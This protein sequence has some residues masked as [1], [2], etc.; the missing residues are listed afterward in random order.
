MFRDSLQF[1]ITDKLQSPQTFQ[2]LLKEYLVSVQRLSNPDSQFLVGLHQ[3]FNVLAQIDAEG[4]GGGG[5]LT[6]N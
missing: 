4:R 5:E 3:H 1:F 2:E 6:R